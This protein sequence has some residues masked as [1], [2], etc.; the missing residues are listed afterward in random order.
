M[1]E[2]EFY[3]WFLIQSKKNIA[4]ISIY[5]LVLALINLYKKEKGVTEMKKEIEIK[6]DKGEWETQV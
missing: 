4:N 1:I 2:R 5:L 3:P 6:E